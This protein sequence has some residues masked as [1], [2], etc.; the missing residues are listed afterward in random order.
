M[1]GT[2]RLSKGMAYNLEIIFE[3]IKNK[4]LPAGGQGGIRLPRGVRSRCKENFPV[5]MEY[6][7]SN[8]PTVCNSFMSNGREGREI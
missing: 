2:A 5:R 6:D 1:R 3:S 8:I 7:S 4:I